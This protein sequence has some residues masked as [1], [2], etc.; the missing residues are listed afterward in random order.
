MRQAIVKYNNISAG[1]LTETDDG[2]YVFE[3]DENFIDREMIKTR[4]SFFYNR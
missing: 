2:D 3:Y 4:S 1:I